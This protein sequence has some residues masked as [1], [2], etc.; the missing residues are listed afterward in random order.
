[1]STFNC[2]TCKSGEHLYKPQI[3][4]S[5][6]CPTLCNTNIDLIS[7]TAF[8]PTGLTSQTLLQSQQQTLFES[9]TSTLIASS[10]QNNIQ[11]QTLIASTLNG[12]LLTYVQ[13]RNSKYIRRN[14]EMIPQSVID[15]QMQTA[16]VGVPHSVF[17]MRDCKGNQF[18]L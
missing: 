1:M 9:N 10:Y 15:L 18:I 8:V 7:S 13:A 2:T 4:I 5:N 14:P 6:C 12:Q 3:F 16:N 17:T 11:N